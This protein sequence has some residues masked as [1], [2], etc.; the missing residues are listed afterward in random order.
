MMR[1]SNPASPASLAPRSSRSP[2]CRAVISC[3]V[4]LCS[5]LLCFAPAPSPWPRSLLLDRPQPGVRHG[6]VRRLGVGRVEDAGEHIPVQPT[7]FVPDEE[8]RTSRDA[9]RLVDDP[10]GGLGGADLEPDQLR[11]PEPAVV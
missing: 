9:D 2:K 4:C 6:V 3:M 11:E 1:P 5:L 10:P 8:S 7:E